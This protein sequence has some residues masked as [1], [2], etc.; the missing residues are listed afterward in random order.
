[1][2]AGANGAALLAASAGVA[3]GH[4]ILPDHWVPL[5][6][7]GR[8]RRYPL[9]RV[10]RLSGM[11]GVAHVLVSIVLGAIVVVVGLQFRSTIQNA[12]DAII[13]GILIV[14]GLGFAVL[15]LTGHGHH[16]DHEHG[17]DHGRGPGHDHDHSRGH[18]PD[19]GHEHGDDPGH[20]HVPGHDDAHGHAHAP[21]PSARRA[22]PR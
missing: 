11:A 6:V 2:S 18:D 17:H 8:T 12:Q 14:T 16:H 10:T 21:R 15:E 22:W 19:H 5:A 1:M 9:A 4:A 20:D 7:L 3:F 13:G